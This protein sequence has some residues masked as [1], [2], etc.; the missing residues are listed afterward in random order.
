MKVSLAKLKKVELQA[1][2]EANDLGFDPDWTK[3]ELVDELEA[4][5]I[6]VES[7]EPGRRESK[8]ERQARLKAR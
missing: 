8:K 3:A 4:A 6:T 1:L 7:D 2:A 5:G